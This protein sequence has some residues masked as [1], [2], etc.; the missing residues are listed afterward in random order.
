MVWDLQLRI[1]G[2]EL[3]FKGTG[4]GVKGLRIREEGCCGKN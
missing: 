3:W 1:W 2:Q 4:S